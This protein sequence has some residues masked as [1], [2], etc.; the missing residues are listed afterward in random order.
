[1]FP[2]ALPLS[3]TWNMTLN[4]QSARTAVQEATAD[5]LIWVFSPIVDIARD[6]RWRRIM[7]GADEDPLLGS[8]VVA[9]MLPPHRA[10]I[11]AGADNRTM[12]QRIDET[13][14]AT[15]KSNV[16]IAVIG[17][18]TKYDQREASSRADIGLPV[19]PQRLLHALFRTVWNSNFRS[20]ETGNSVAAVLF[21]Y[22]NPVSKLTA[23]ISTF[24]WINLTLLQPQDQRPRN[25]SDFLDQYR[26]RYLDIPNDP[27]YP[28][29]YGLIYTTFS[30]GPLNPVKTE[31]HGG[32]DRLTIRFAISN[33]DAYYVK[34]IIQLY[35][36]DLV[37]SVTRA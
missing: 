22:Y 21:E 12:T 16:F 33:T 17:Q 6:P 28:F 24:S 20:T 3:A 35:I 8:Q 29:N 27:L 14:A 36:G 26:S 31:L 25:S 13:V 2:F 37:A 10:A 9:A 15:Q 32:S 34:E 23:N 5:A 19:C 1:M 18:I 4:E 30:F 7:E 11:D